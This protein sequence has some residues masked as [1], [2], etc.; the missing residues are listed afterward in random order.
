[1]GIRSKGSEVAEPWGAREVPERWDHLT[2]EPLEPQRCLAHSKKLAEHS[3][4]HQNS[5]ID[6]E[7]RPL[8]QAMCG[9]EVGPRGR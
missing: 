3:S 8:L 6:A 7:E 5:Q 2:L 4:Q 1:M 9:G